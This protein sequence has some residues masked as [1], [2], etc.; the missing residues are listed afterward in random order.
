MKKICN[1][2]ADVKNNLQRCKNCGNAACS[3]CWKGGKSSTGGKI[4]RGIGALY[5]VGASEAVRSSVRKLKEK[6]PFCSNDSYIN[7]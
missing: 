6:C 1:S 2:C 5:T 3:K 7:V 4:L